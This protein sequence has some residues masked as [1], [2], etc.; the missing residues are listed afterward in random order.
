MPDAWINYET[1]WRLRHS[2]TLLL[3][4]LVQVCSGW[5]VGGCRVHW[6]CRRARH[7]LH[8]VQVA[9]PSQPHTL[10]RIPTATLEKQVNLTS[11]SLNCARKPE[12]LEETH[13]G[14][15]RTR[16]L[17]TKSPTNRE[18]ETQNVL[19]IIFYHCCNMLA[20][21]NIY[22]CKQVVLFCVLHF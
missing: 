12:H 15:A 22:S 11:V 9:S 5:G 2:S 21:C 16:K 7:E 6:S 18:I 17:H 3:V 19:A 14:T 1:G 20:L 10:T 4:Q 8:P 13:A